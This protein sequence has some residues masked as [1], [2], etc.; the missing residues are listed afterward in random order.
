[1]ITVTGMIVLRTYKPVGKRFK[2]TYTM[3][4]ETDIIRVSQFVDDL[5]VCE[6]LQTETT[7]NVSVNVFNNVVELIVTNE[8]AENRF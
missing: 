3:M 2:V 4:D 6:T 1:M 5:S 8:S 7:F